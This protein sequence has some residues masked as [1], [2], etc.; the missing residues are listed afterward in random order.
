MRIKKTVIIV[1]CSVVFSLALGSFGAI[2][3]LFLHHYKGK[4]VVNNWSPTDQFDIN[5]IPVLNKEKGK[6]FTILNFADIQ[7][8]DL[9]R[10]DNHEVVHKE[11]DYL[12]ATYKPDLITLTGDQTWSNENLICLKSLISWL[13]SYRVPF[14]PVFGNHD[15]GN[16]YDSS[17]AS[18]TYCCDLYE[19][20]KYSLF[21]RGPTNIGSLG[22]Y[23]INIKEDNQI[24]NTIY[25]MDYGYNDKITDEQLEWFK[26]TADGIKESNGGNYTNG[27]IFMHKPIDEFRYAYNH[28][29]NEDI[30][31][32]PIFSA[33]KERN[34][35][36]FVCG[37]YHHWNFTD[38]FRDVTF[39]MATK[40]GEI[41][42]FYEDE[43]KYINGA[44]SF[45]ISDGKI[46]IN[47]NYV[48]REGFRIKK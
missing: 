23:A 40:T 13:E 41:F 6:D 12:V 11:L 22:N 29:D 10:W 27:F 21:N 4:E 30:A 47:H 9:E 42:D 5:K 26:W 32:T 38:V 46:I 39:T 17:T 3:F 16:E 18:L 36:N 1:T 28:Y 48:N 15:Y 43:D 19:N 7:M 45:T 24:I 20:A 34:V 37:H 31:I 35:T 44:T 25:M 2:Y 33:A 8:C 14:A